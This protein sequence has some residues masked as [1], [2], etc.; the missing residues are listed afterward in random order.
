MKFLAI[1]R[2][3]KKTENK[4]R[5]QA[6]HSQPCRSKNRK[7]LVP[8]PLPFWEVCSWQRWTFAT[9]P[10]CTEGGALPLAS[11]LQGSKEGPLQNQSG[12]VLLGSIAA[13]TRV[14]SPF[15]KLWHNPSERVHLERYS[16]P[17]RG[18]QG[19]RCGMQNCGADSGFLIC[20]HEKLPSWVSYRS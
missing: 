13:A 3:W 6:S 19:R 16:S 12:R 5:F 10:R 8:S 15:A 9:H 2:H 14:R 7:F 20:S 17:K 11:C 18:W 4:H 1:I